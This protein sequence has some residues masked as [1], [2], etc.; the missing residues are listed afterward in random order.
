MLTNLEDAENQKLK[1]ILMGNNAKKAFEL[2]RK[3]GA[4]YGEDFTKTHKKQ[5][6][7]SNESTAEIVSEINP[8]REIIL[9][10]KGG[11]WMQLNQFS[12]STSLDNETVQNPLIIE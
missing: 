9:R 5:S 6:A 7:F 8:T 2:M 4:N 12:E 1:K 3:E 10:N 11:K